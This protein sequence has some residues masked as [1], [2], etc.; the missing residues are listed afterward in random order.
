MI[1]EAPY[2]SFLTLNRLL[3]SFRCHVAAR[4]VH[5]RRSMQNDVSSAA[6]STLDLS[7][8]GLTTTIDA[9]TLDCT[10]DGVVLGL[11]TSADGGC[12]YTRRL[13]QSYTEAP[14]NILPLGEMRIVHQEPGS[15][16]VVEKPAFLPSENTRTIKDSVRARLEAMPHLGIEA[17]GDGRPRVR[18]AHRL[19]WETSGLLV[20]ALNAD[21]M[22][23]LAAQFAARSV[24]KAY[25]ADVVRPLAA[26]RAAKR[27]TIDLPLSDDPE[28]RPC[29]RVDY[30]PG[31]KAAST[32]WAIEEEA[33]HACRMRLEPASGRRHQLRMHMLA[34][35]AAIAGDGLYE[36]TAAVESSVTDDE[37]ADTA[38]ASAAQDSRPPRL[39]LH[40]AELGFAH[41]AT[42]EAL[43][44]RS[45]PPFRLEAASRWG[46]VCDRGRIRNTA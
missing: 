41:P 38:V 11:L 23:S 16:V 17:D 36:D 22:R 3:S 33:A 5:P 21:A 14:E 20:V 45:E 42:G 1:V 29:Q 43:T 18:L 28:R 34:L 19:D 25:V 39:H 12:T 24:R 31:G 37:S 8:E 40:A 35:G 6:S 7:G 10:P 4:L 32:S 44:F 2:L 9:A 15:F 26:L 13:G 30:G 46:A 27:G